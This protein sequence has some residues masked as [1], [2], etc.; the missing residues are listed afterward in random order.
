VL[1]IQRVRGRRAF[2]RVALAAAE[3]NPSATIL[4]SRKA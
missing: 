2:G 4:I 3:Q 1:G